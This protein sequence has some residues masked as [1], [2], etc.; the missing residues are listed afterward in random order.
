MVAAANPSA[1]EWVQTCGQSP[2]DTIRFYLRY[3]RVHEELFY[4]RSG[5]GFADVA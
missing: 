4:E 3:A 5:I 2:G 1:C